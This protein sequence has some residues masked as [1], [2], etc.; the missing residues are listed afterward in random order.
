MFQGFHKEGRIMKKLT[1]RKAIMLKADASKVWD[2]LVNPDLTRQYMFGCE[3]IS[4]WKQ[5]SPITWRGSSKGA[6]KIFAEGWIRKIEPGKL[7][8]VT[9]IDSDAKNKLFHSRDLTATYQII[10][11]KGGTLLSVAQGNYAKLKN[12]EEKYNRTENDWDNALDGLKSIVEAGFKN[13]S[14]APPN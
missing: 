8:Q 2:A 9:T 4:D 1:V 5:G 11:G 12:G 13:S 3:V 7:L 14:S 10:Q 6:E